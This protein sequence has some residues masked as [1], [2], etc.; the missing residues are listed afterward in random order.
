VAGGLGL[1]LN[2]VKSLV[3]QQGGC[4]GV[5]SAPG[6]GASFWFTLPVAGAGGLSPRELEVA[7]LVTRGASN[8]QIAQE[9]VL[10]E[11]TIDSHVSHIL[12]KL[13]LSSRTQIA[14]WV[15]EHRRAA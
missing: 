12:R 1:G 7:R 8:R 5:D 9:L 4:V 15:M 10:S 13:A 6:Q 2:I 3:Q 14:T 11:R